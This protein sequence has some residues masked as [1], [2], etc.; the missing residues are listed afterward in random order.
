MFLNRVLIIFQ[1][2]RIPS[3][4]IKEES[5][6][7][8]DSNTKASDIQPLGRSRMQHLLRATYFNK[9][10]TKNYICKCLF[11]SRNFLLHSL[12]LVVLD[13]WDKQIVKIHINRVLLLDLERLG[14]AT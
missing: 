2:Q 8:V 7:Q 12:F 13:R 14:K 6:N 1:L 10:P 11:F 9:D 5:W 3:D 4:I